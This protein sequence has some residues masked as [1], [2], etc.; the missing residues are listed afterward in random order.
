MPPAEFIVHALTERG[1]TIACA[2]TLTGG[3]IAQTLIRVPGSSR[4]LNLSVVAYSDQAKV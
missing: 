3:G 2:E 4:V 1:L